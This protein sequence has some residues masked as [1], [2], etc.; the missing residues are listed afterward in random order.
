MKK[1]YVLMLIIP[2]CFCIEDSWE[3]DIID[4]FSDILDD[5]TD[6]LLTNIPSFITNINEKLEDFKN[7]AD[8]KKTEIIESTQNE[9]EEI[10][11]KIKNE[12]ETHIKPLIEK[13]IE[14]ANYLPYKICDSLSGDCR[15]DK[16]KI[17]L[18]LLDTL[19]DELK[20]SRLISLIT[21]KQITNDLELNLKY[22]LFLINTL[23]KSPDIISFGKSI[24]I[25][26]V[27]NCL[28][29]KFEKY[30]PIVLEKITGKP[31]N[32]NI[33]L[34]IDI[35]K[36]LID[37]ISNLVNIIHFGEIDG[38]I[39]KIN[40]KTGL[41]SNEN[42]KNIQRNIF[43][44][45]KKLFE[46]GT[47]FYNINNRLLLNITI[48]PGKLEAGTDLEYEISNYKE[49][50]IKVFLHSKYLFRITGAQYMQTI[51][52]DSPLISIKSDI[53]NGGTSNTFVGIV[54]YD[55]EG[56]EIKLKEININA[57]RPVIYFKKKLINVMETCVFYNE[58]EDK[59]DN[60]GIETQKEFLDGEEYIKCIPKH[61]SSF[62]IGTYNQ[63]SISGN[64]N[65]GSFMQIS[66]FSIFLYYLLL[67]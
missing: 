25:Y 58:I 43:E 50:G 66:L 48:N 7:Y 41:I 29:E 5:I 30:F 21:T 4:Y 31:N 2:I 20:C 65:N 64:S 67:L 24:I 57:F 17:F 55:K 40:E 62:T 16:K 44:A 46:F 13:A 6:K 54:L 60:T 53:A 45:S 38:Y 8:E 22:I 3:K 19:K 35:I 27:I 18:K 26:D 37:S 51:V 52:F 39:E 23:I 10:Y 28:L 36:I 14:L 34:K 32:Y 12:E 59:M 1:F 49:K 9:I 56:N 61:L 11:K 42:A 63:A 47:Q 15:G 33:T